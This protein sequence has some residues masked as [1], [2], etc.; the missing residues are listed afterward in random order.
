M[1]RQKLGT[2]NW[3]PKLETL[4]TWKWSSELLFSR[5]CSKV[6]DY[7]RKLQ[8]L[9]WTTSSCEFKSSWSWF[10]AKNIN[11]FYLLPYPVV[12]FLHIANAYS[13]RLFVSSSVSYS[14]VLVIDLGVHIHIL[15]PWTDECA[16][17]DVYRSITRYSRL[18]SQ[19]NGNINGTRELNITAASTWNEIRRN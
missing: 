3:I 5:L 15:S 11:K 4:I 18:L 2:R 6:A 10:P 19:F 7:S 12:L 17:S 13:A 16:E 1:S 14:S 9:F 8:W